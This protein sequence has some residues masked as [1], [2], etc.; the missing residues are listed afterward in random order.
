[1]NTARQEL[2]VLVLN[3][4]AKPIADACGVAWPVVVAWS[5]GEHRPDPVS[6]AILEMD[7]KI[8]EVT[9]VEIP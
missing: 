5:R 4:G 1:M 3:K 9:W 8:P 6:R 2:A 7:F